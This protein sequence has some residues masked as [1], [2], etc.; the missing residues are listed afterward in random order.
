MIKPR[1]KT[2]YAYQ[3]FDIVPDSGEFDWVD[4][5]NSGKFEAFAD[6]QE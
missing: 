6:K 3:A 4:Y 5:V 1:F 2:Y